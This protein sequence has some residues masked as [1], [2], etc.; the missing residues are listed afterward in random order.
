MCSETYVY[1]R[2]DH[3]TNHIKDN[4]LDL[5]EYARMLSDSSGISHRSS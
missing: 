2:H 3:I 5:Q 4:E 1:G